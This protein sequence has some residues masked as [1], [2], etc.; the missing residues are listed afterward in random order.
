MAAI[1][2]S[3]TAQPQTVVKTCP[4]CLEEIKEIAERIETVCKHFFHNECLMGWLKN[5]NTCPSC[6]H[7][8]VQPAQ[9]HHAPAMPQPPQVPMQLVQPLL[10][11]NA[12]LNQLNQGPVQ[13]PHAQVGIQDPFFWRNS[14]GEEFY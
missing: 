2:S 9:A 4:I 14:T 8:L 1:P 10:Y 7:I 11:L 12:V 6:R 13:A 5:Q 3:G